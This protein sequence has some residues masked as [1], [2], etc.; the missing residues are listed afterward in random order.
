MGREQKLK[1]SSFKF[2]T[3]ATIEPEMKLFSEL[4][5]TSG[6]LRTSR[7]IAVGA[8]PRVSLA[9]EMPSFGCLVAEHGE[10]VL[11]SRHPCQ[12]GKR[13]VSTSGHC[14]ARVRSKTLWFLADSSAR[15]RL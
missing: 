5:C 14:T 12:P 15:R 9:D 8:N 2:I 1:G 10:S 13:R 11:S 4:K 6:G 7:A 3:S